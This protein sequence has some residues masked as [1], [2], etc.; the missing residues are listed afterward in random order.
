[1]STMFR[2]SQI[3]SRNVV[4]SSGSLECL[5][6]ETKHRFAFPSDVI[7][8]HRECEHEEIRIGRVVFLPR[9][10]AE[11]SLCFAVLFFSIT[12]VRWYAWNET[13]CKVWYSD[14]E[15]ETWKTSHEPF[16]VF[17]QRALHAHWEQ[18]R[19]AEARRFQ[20]C[21]HGRFVP[22]PELHPNLTN[23]LEYPND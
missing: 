15:R 14:D 7:D 16:A 19:Q 18:E 1:M 9:A 20:K 13:D 2:L 3:G 10:K 4:L 12:T 17:M 6:K 5:R 22:S 23:F 11:K 21:V 8:L